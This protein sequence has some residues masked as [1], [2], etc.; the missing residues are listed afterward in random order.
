MKIFDVIE[1]GN[2][3]NCPVLGWRVLP[4]SAW[5][6]TRNPF[7]VPDFPG[8]ITASAAL[9]LKVCKLGKG[10]PGRFAFRYFE[11]VAP[12]VVFRAE[13]YARQLRAQG[14]PDTPAYAFDKAVVTGEFRKLTAD[15]NISVSLTL[16]S[17]KA[18][19]RTET[20]DAEF[21]LPDFGNRI[22][23]AIEVLSRD[24]TLKTGDLILIG[25]DGEAVAVCQDSH[26]RFAGLAESEGEDALEI[27]IK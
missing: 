25:L 2:N 21:A 12:A 15:G 27:S 26:L 5:L 6:K 23:E 10:I 24:N 14:L 11:E 18:D 3:G 22:A 17:R 8:E 20:V 7:F 4:D 13:E 1:K 19:S 9:A 16:E